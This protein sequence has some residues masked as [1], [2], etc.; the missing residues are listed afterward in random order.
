[1]TPPPPPRGKGGNT[2]LLAVITNAALDRLA[3]Q[4]VAVMS[5]AAAA[6]VVDPFHTPEDGD[7]CFALS[8]QSARLPQGYTAGDVGVL[9]GRLVQDAI[10]G[11]VEAATR[12]P[13]R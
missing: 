4:R 1:P 5:N 12:P 6:R 13:R 3:L 2:L 8:T 9:A 10:V 11:A 7:V